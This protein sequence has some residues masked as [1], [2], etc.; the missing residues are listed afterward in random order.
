MNAATPDLRQLI[1]GGLLTG[2]RSG[3]LAPARSRDFDARSETLLIP[4]SNSGKPRR[5][6]LTWEGVGLLES[7][8]AGR[9]AD[10]LLFTPLD[11]SAWHRVAVIRR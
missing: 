6:P 11:G 1:Q 4:D 10:E 5:V 3:E 7:L 2:C 9:K 8:A